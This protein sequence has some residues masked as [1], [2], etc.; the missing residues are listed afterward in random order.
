LAVSP[1]AG[2]VTTARATV[3]TVP[4]SLDDA[5]RRGLEHNLAVVLA[6]QDQRMASGRQLQGLDF[7]LPN[8]SAQATRS[9]NQL[10]IEALGFRPGL[11]AQLPP[12]FLPSG[13]TFNPIITV[14]IVSAQANLQQSLFNLGA[15]EQYR[16]AKEGQTAANYNA[17]FTRGST[18]QQIAVTY[19]LALADAANVDNAR[20]LLQ[21][22]TVLLQQAMDAN[23]A[24]TATHLDVLRAQVQYQQQE[25]ALI[26]SQNALDK[27][28][29]ALLRQI[30]LPAEQPIRLTDATPYAD[31]DQ[32]GLAQARQEAYAHRQDYLALQ[33]QVRAAEH[34]RRAARMER[35]PTLGFQGN[36]GVTGT[37][38]SVYHGTFIAAGSLSVPLFREASL[39]GD[40]DVAEAGLAKVRAQLADLRTKIDGQLRD[41]LLD[42]ASTRQLVQVARSNA[43]LAQQSLND[44]TDRFQNGVDDTLPVVEAQA[45]LAAAQAQL[46]NSLYQ[47]NRSKLGL[48]WDLGVLEEQYRA[49]LGQ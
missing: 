40:R 20:G 37:V 21:A 47:F 27:A 36:Y 39:R 32:M 2:S 30:G 44:A 8:L 41:S 25:Q 33:A 18:I 31:L 28:K 15:L 26:A 48:A 42:I 12:G 23:Q 19:L 3:E 4:L 5:I 14:N 16:A 35:L 43:D 13:P 49:Y 45:T 34:Q 7:L 6:R 22:D 1:Y 11:L 9:R 38:G 46:V 29:I 17:Q 10:N 24:G